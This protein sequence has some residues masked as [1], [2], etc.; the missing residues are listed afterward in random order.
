MIAIPPEE[1]KPT[2]TKIPKTYG[3][4]Y[5]IP[6]PSESELPCVIRLA[7]AV[8]CATMVTMRRAILI[9][10]DGCGVGAAPDAAAFGD[11]HG[12]NTLAH[13]YEAAPFSAP[14]LAGVGLLA[15]AGI[16]SKP[17][18]GAWGRLRPMSQGGKDSVTGHW[19]MAGIRV[20]E[21]FPTYPDG[22]PAELVHAF[23]RRIGVQV[24]GNQAA[25]GTEILE[26][27]G[28]ESARTGRPILYTSADSVF[29]VAAHEEAVPIERLYAWCEIGRELT[30]VQRVIAR[31]FVGH[32]GAWTRTEKRK[33]WPLEPPFNVVDEIG[34]VHGIGV[35]PELF[36]GRG[37][38]AVP[39][40]QS[41]EQHGK[42]L[43]DALKGRSRFIW[44]NFEDFDMKYGHRSDPAG[45]SHCLEEFDG[46]LSGLLSR[47]GEGDLLILTAD[48]GNDPTDDSTDHTR[49]YVPVVLWSPGIDARALG[50]V[51]GF[52]AVGATVAAWLGV[53]WN[54]GIN[55][56]ARSA[57]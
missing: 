43:L 50:D 3:D 31:P 26:R 9:V 15:A 46:Y 10:L 56:L 48:H 16:P 13:V 4:E 35:V 20:A 27:L 22:F 32:V 12:P 47:L 8:A 21:R 24:L 37:F 57:S 28:E 2:S 19:E 7:G 14:T 36:G 45:F 55:L 25:S 38:L 42:A 23:E 39:R 41:N 11:T 5:S 40:T 51:E 29:Q 44:A 18:E 52:D 6:S 17:L 54:R 30:S 34:G 33:D 49:E 53:D 1:E